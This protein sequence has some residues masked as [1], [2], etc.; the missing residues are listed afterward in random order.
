MQYPTLDG[1]ACRQPGS[2]CE[3]WIW[4][5]TNCGDLHIP[6][7]W[8]RVYFSV[9]RADE[10]DEQVESLAAPAVLPRPAPVAR[11][12]DDMVWIEPCKITVGPDPSDGQASPAQQVTLD[13]YWIDRYPVTIYQFSQLLDDTGLDE[14]YVEQMA[15]PNECGILSKC[16][17]YE[18]VSGREMFPIVYITHTAATQYAAWYDRML[19]TEAQWERAARDTEGRTYPWGQEPPTPERAN[20]DYHY[21][22]TTRVGSFPSGTTPEGIV[23]LAGNVKEWCRDE[24]H[25]YPGGGPMLDFVDRAVDELD[26]HQQQGLNRE[27]F[28]V[29][30]GGFSKQAANLMSAYRDADGPG[31]WFFSL[32]FRC[33]REEE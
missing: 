7:A 22:G 8:G 1:E 24:Y 3:D 31:R 16:G 17:G 18:V 14:L 26:L 21:G 6:E 13:G 5:S 2:R 28:S 23:D 19:P 15:N 10:T 12:V 29:R 11:D 32:G 25:S 20:Y 27:L 33:M 9:L 4:N 30:G